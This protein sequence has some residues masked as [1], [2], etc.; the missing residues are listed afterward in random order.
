MRLAW[1]DVHLFLTI[2]RCG[3]L[4]AA[5]RELAVDVSTVSRRLAQLE[6]TTGA[7]LLQRNSRR[8]EVTAAGAQVV[9]AGERMALEVAGLARKIASSDARLGGVVRVTAPGSLLPMLGEAVAALIQSHPQIEVE[10]LSLD[11]LLPLDGSQIDVAV[12]IADAPPEHLV[13]VRVARLR[14]GVYASTAYLARHRAALDH[15]SHTWVEWDRRLAGKPAFQWAAQR[16][17]HRRVAARGLSTLDVHALV[18]AG[19]GIGALPRVVGDADAQL[20]LLEEVPDSVASS[21]WLLTHPELRE[22]PRVR[23]LLAAL[24]RVLVAHK[25]QF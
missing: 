12:R 4:R 18:R 16:F 11:A 8:L 19:A 6:Q 7:R 2:V 20:R 14:A 9:S 23:T 13:G 21:I 5:A 10:L 24:K 22:V 25:T 15:A 1:D 3:S 17:P